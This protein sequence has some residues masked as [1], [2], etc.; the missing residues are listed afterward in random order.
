[1][2]RVPGTFI[3]LFYDLNR[4]RDR[5]PPGLYFFE[6]GNPQ[7]LLAQIQAPTLILW[8]ME[9]PHVVHLDADVM[10][11]WMTNA[12]CTIRKYPHLGHYPYL[13]DPPLVNGDIKAF[14][15]GHLDGKLLVTRRVKPEELA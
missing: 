9:N 2:D 14:L 15:C 4:C 6:T 3:D 13:E 8:G 12:P 10:E 1:M 7:A 5:N 11:H